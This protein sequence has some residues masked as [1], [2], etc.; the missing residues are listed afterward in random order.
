MD[1]TDLQDE[2]FQSLPLSE[3]IEKMHKVITDAL[4]RVYQGSFQIQ[5]SER[6]AALALH[7]QMELA[8]FLSQAEFSAKRAKGEVKYITG[9][10]NFELRSKSSEKKI[11]EEAVKQLVN[12]DERIKEADLKQ[13]ELEREASQWGYIFESLKDAHIFFRNLGK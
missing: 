3:R 1:E 8:K 2:Q 11:T 6:Y 4:D 10:L 12:K 5:K 13:Y 7:A 9:E